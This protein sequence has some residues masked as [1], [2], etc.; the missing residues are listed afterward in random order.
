MQKTALVTILLFLVAAWATAQQPTSPAPATV[1]GQEKTEPTPSADTTTIEGCLGGAA[2]NF[3]ITDKSGMIY[4]LDVPEGTVTAVEKHLGKEVQV[5]GTVKNAATGSAA[6]DS[7]AAKDSA[8]ETSKS[9]ATIKPAKMKK[10]ADTCSSPTQSP[11]A[12]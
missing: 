6:A 9:Q 12:K 7:G 11:S 3:T 5:T 10:L 2:G 4:K 1:P 8:L